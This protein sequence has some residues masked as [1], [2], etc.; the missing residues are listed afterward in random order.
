MNQE[1]LYRE[2]EYNSYEWVSIMTKNLLEM[3]RKFL[4]MDDE[5]ASE[6]A[7]S[8]H[9]AANQWSIVGQRNI[10]N[11]AILFESRIMTESLLSTAR[12]IIKKSNL[13]TKPIALLVKA[14]WKNFRCG[15]WDMRFYR[16]E[17]DETV[18]YYMDTIPATTASRIISELVLFWVEPHLAVKQDTALVE[19]VLL[20]YYLQTPHCRM[21]VA[22]NYMRQMSNPQEHP[23]I[24][25]RFRLFCKFIPQVT[26]LESLAYEFYCAKIKE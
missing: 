5:L 17:F 8:L 20:N 9:C 12:T 11:K 21:S 26:S 1:C 18:R 7:F 2:R 24:L 4:H 19:D 14:F 23:L 16:K 3:G 15:K 13:G 22:C 10:M 25:V 6:F